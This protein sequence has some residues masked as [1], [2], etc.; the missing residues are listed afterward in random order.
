MS[1]VLCPVLKQLILGPFWCEV[2]LVMWNVTMSGNSWSCSPA[3]IL[4]CGVLLAK[5]AVYSVL[6]S[7]FLLLKAC[8][9][10]YLSG[11][12]PKIIVTAWE[13]GTQSRCPNHWSC[14]HCRPRCPS[15]DWDPATP[16]EVQASQVASYL[17][18]QM[19][20]PHFYS[21]TNYSRFNGKMQ[22]IEINEFEMQHRNISTRK[23]Q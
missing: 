16:A 11:S 22:V 14:Y 13:P 3:N 20:T 5:H 21:K 4:L 23:V 6:L 1:E 2:R 9:T 12:F 17:P 19:T 15:Q 10:F 7:F 8:L 18:G